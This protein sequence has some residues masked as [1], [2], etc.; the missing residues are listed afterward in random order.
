LEFGRPLRLCRYFSFG[1]G[2]YRLFNATLPTTDERFTVIYSGGDKKRKGV[3][4]ILRREA[5]SNSVT[6]HNIR[7]Y[8]I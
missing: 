8:N 6:S 4:F 1:A 5:K 7:A 3:D 2:R